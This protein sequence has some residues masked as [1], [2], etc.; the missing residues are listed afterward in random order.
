MSDELQFVVM[1]LTNLTFLR[2]T[3]KNRRSDFGRTTN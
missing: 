3:W 2:S 1:P